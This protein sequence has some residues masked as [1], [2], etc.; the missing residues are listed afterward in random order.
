MDEECD[1]CENSSAYQWRMTAVEK[2]V[3]RLNS[4][5]MGTLISS[6]ST[7]VGVVVLLVVN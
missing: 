3:D 5:L 6:I 1:I 2:K 4:M 7:L